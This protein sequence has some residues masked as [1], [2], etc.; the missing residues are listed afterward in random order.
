LFD[1]KT[2]VPKKEGP[3]FEIRVKSKT[4]VLFRPA[5]HAAPTKP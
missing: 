5:T 3:V 1:V 2:A 4:P